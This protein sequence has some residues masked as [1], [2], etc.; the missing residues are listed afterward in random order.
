M[1]KANV[2]QSRNSSPS[3]SMGYGQR[4]GREALRVCLP[5]RLSHAYS[6]P[7]PDRDDEPDTL[8]GI[9]CQAAPRIER[10]VS[11]DGQRWISSNLAVCRPR[12]VTSQCSYE[13]QQDDHERVLAHSHSTSKISFQVHY[14]P[15]ICLSSRVANVDQLSSI[16]CRSQNQRSHPLAYFCQPWLEGDLQRQ[17]QREFNLLVRGHQVQTFGPGAFDTIFV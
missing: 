7:R 8:R 17:R 10:V 2:G 9:P 3:K 11:T 5:A 12:A 6:P 1:Q 16:L 4:G 14:S 15:T 13:Q